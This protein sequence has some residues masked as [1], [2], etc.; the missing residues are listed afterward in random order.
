MHIQYHAASQVAGLQSL[1][2]LLYLGF[3]HCLVQKWYTCLLPGQNG[4]VK[5]QVS[6]SAL[7]SSY[8]LLLCVL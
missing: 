7:Q 3:R 2:E 8:R 6:L 4:V 1:M 5:N